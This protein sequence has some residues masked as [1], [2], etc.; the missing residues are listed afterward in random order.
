MALRV[1]QA[2]QQPGARAQAVRERSAAR[3][4]R[5]LENPGRLRIRT[6]DSLNRSLAL[7]DAAGGARQRRVRRPAPTAKCIPMAARRALLD[8]QTDAQ[9][10]PDVQRL[11]ETHGE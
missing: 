10:R 4:W 9:L 8:A 1:T 6:L 2:L 11:F 5:L 3:G 7:A